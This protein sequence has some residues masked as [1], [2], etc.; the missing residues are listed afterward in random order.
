MSNKEELQHTVST[1][2]ERAIAE[3]V[4]LD[5]LHLTRIEPGTALIDDLGLDSVDL[6]TVVYD[7]EVALNR[8][9]PISQWLAQ[10]G[11]GEGTAAFTMAALVQHIVD[12]MLQP[13]TEETA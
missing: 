4:D 7:I 10:Y 2:V 9:L 3:Q 13:A 8:K 5:R 6:F 12:F 1:V 11:G